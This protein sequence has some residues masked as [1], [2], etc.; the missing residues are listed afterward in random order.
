L[1]EEQERIL[2]TR[3]LNNERPAQEELYRTYADKMFA[4]CMTYA[5]DRDEASD[6][7]QNGFMTVY[8]KLHLFSFN[9]SFEGWIRRIMVNSALS[10]LRKKKRF[11]DMLEN[12]EYEQELPEYESDLELIPSATVIAKVNELPSKSAMVLKL[13]AIEGFTH[14]EIAEIMGVSVGTSKSQLNRARTLLKKAF[15]RK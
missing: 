11:T 14:K 2:I 4:V 13:Y 9:G 10:V 5:E 8:S 1:N 12:I 3:C 7:L 15:N 6:F